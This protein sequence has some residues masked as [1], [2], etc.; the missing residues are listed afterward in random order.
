MRNKW[1]FT[2]SACGLLLALCSA[3]LFS[4]QPRAQ[5]PVFNP[6]ADPYARGI[7]ADGVVES[8][9]DQGENINL[10]PEVS[11]P[12]TQVLVAEGQSVHRGDALLRVD[13]SVQRALTDQQQAQAEA[14]LATLRELK[15]EPR[16]EALAVAAAQVQ[17]AQ[18]TLKNADDELAKQQRSYDMD[19]RSISMDALDNARN[20]QKIAATNLQVVQRQYELTRAG[21]WTYDVQ[22]QE[23][24]YEALSRSYRSASALLAKYTLRAPEDGVV[25]AVQAPVGSYISP[26]GAYDSYTQG[27]GPVLVMGSSQQRLQVRAYIDEILVHELPDASRMRAQMFIRGTSQQ[28]ALQFVRVQ[29]YIS[30]KIE[31]SD[32]REERV[33]LRVLPVVFRFQNAPALHLYPGELVDVYVSAQ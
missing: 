11:G 24:T 29:P 9:Q 10:Y 22:N 28:V 3:L 6:A 19:P 8:D 16:P 33:D 17:N 21:A 32:E 14:A 20:A 13:E 15:A 27:Y 31:L 18:A 12:V 2:V 7:Y 5:V 23:R 1:L 25:L 26:Q 4:R 30:P